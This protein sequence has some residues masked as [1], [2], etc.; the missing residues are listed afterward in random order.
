[1]PARR[2]L[3]LW[4]PRLAAERWLRAEP[5]LAERPFAVVGE[6]QGAQVIA[7]PGLVAAQ[8]GLHPGQ[9]LRDAHAMCAGLITRPQDDHRD[10]A[11]L[12]ALHRWS[13]RYSPWVAVQPPDSLVIDLTGC[14]H[15]FGGEA[16]LAPQV[17]DDCAA[18]GLTARVGIADTL[19]A[20]WAPK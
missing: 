2:I 10:E 8:A 6:A 4:F 7:S 18:L 9:P 1:M 17:I 11:F 13:G 19:G 16:A 20:A 5:W 12:T 3:S 15:L 14:A